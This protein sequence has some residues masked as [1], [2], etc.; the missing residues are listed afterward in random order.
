MPRK[1]KLVVD[2]LAVDSFETKD[3]AEAAGTVHG[4][5]LGFDPVDDARAAA[6]CLQTR[7]GNIQC[8]A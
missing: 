7:C 4:Q 1:H 8:C 6:T 5:E 3:I 2:G